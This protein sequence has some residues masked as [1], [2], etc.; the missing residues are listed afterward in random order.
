M[1]ERKMGKRKMTTI[2]ID[3][4]LL[5]KAHDLGLN[6]S[7]LSENALKDAIDRMERPKTKNDGGERLEK[8]EMARDVGI[9]P[10]RSKS[11]S[12]SLTL[13][14]YLSLKQRLS[15]AMFAIH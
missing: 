12:Y 2:R 8:V 13:R 10:T 4:E 5:T 14:N 6:V 7:K 15:V 1:G 9:E 11:L 3:E